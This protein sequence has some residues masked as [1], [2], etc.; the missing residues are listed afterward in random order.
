MAKGHMK[1]A[2]K[3]LEVSRFESDFSPM[4]SIS[5]SL[6]KIASTLG[7]YSAYKSPLSAV[8]LCIYLSCIAEERPRT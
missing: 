1:K 7:I 6:T 4:T 2:D 3:K 8:Y 5:V